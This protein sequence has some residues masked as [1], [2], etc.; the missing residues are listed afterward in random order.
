MSIRN[1]DRLFRPGSVAV[2]G[3]TLRPQ[4]VGATVLANLRAG[5][6]GGAIY[7]VNPK[8]G[9]LLDAPCYPNIRALPAPPDL[10][11]ICTPPPTVPGLVAELAAA[12]TRAAIVLTAGLGPADGQL[13]RKMQEAARPSL[14]RL[15][16][17]NCL[18]LISPGIGLNASFAPSGAP[19]G[20]LAFATQSGAM[21]TAVLD[22]ARSRQ[23]GFSHFVSL[24]DSLDIDVADVLDYLAGDRDTRAILLYVEAIRHGRKFMSAARAAARSKPVLIVKAGRAPEGARAAATHTGALA[25][26]DDVYDAVIRR[27]GM[28]RVDSTGELFD[29][30]ET[31]ARARPVGGSRLAILTNGG[32]AGVMAAD[33]LAAGGGTLATL[34]PA[35]LAALDRVLPPSWSHAD[36]VDVLG[37]APVAR[38]VEAGRILAHAPE[39]DAVLLLHAPTAIVPAAGIADAIVQARQRQDLPLFTGWLGGDA[40]AGARQ[41]C[42]AAGIPTYDTPEQAVRAFLQAAEYRRN[43]A[44]L[45]QTPPAV[46]DGVEPDRAGAHSV[47]EAALA[48]GRRMLSESESKQVLAAYGI[49]VIETVRA[50]NAD[51]AA[52]VAASLGFPVAL[53]IASP[54]ITHKSAVGGVALDLDGPDAVRAAALAMT[55]RV[56]QMRPQAR[57]E[58]FTVQRMARPAD[59]VELILGVFTDPV[60]GPVILFGHGGTAVEQIRDHAIALPPMNRLVAADLVQRTRVARLLAHPAPGGP[61]NPTATEAVLTALTRLS[62]LVCEMGELAELDINPLIA[63]AEGVLALDARIAVAPAQGSPR[64]R[65][66]ILP[67]PRELETRLTWHGAPLLLRPIR[68]ED[69]DALRTF[70]SHMTPE[71]IHSRYFCSFRDPGHAQLARLTQIDYAREMAFVAMAEDA[72]NPGA[73]SQIVGEARA[74]ADPDNIAAEFGVVVRS[75]WKGRGLGSL[76]LGKL[77]AYARAHGTRE[78]TGTVLAGNRA[79]L[80]LAKGQGFAMRTQADGEVVDVRLSL[81]AG[82]SITPA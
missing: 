35:T 82:A 36:P 19:V 25:G 51:A 13:C 40:V 38:Y 61:A 1:L 67:Y 63:S 30:V 66:A 12:G 60:F 70:Y 43:L 64:D 76:L 58:G 47:I 28:L 80:A 49:P 3:A 15:L 9:T 74:V 46:T 5:G 79:M 62:N 65:L 14:L 33:A 50:A 69:E 77:L 72:R 7:A 24:G 26:R 48:E 4:S 39:A 23:I 68:P 59:A 20:T 2:I 54:D 73:A 27:A 8:Y 41:A 37:D 31:L 57:L 32:G 17:P 71:D 45:A 11:V 52:T 29:A 56:G 18:G 16:G 53:K 78:L 55:A 42:R 10:A 75:D 22:W 81:A 34:T 6:F 21:A 44:L